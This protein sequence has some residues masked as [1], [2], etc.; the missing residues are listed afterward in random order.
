MQ[1]RGGECRG[2]GGEEEGGTGGLSQGSAAEAL[3]STLSLASFVTLDKSPSISGPQFLPLDNKIGGSDAREGS[4]Q[5]WPSPIHKLGPIRWQLMAREGKPPGPDAQIAEV[6]A[7]QAQG[8]E[9]AKETQ[10]R[11]LR[12]CFQP[13]GQLAGREGG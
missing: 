4:F 3:V 13:P 8:G 10:R 5:G 1:K 7:T 6:G 2:G 11:E 12:H 9:L